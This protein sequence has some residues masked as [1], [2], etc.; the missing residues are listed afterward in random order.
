MA[1]AI[2]RLMCFC[3]ALLLFSS[4]LK[5]D[6]SNISDEFDWE[7]SLSISLSELNIGTDD[8]Y[9]GSFSNNFVLFPFTIDADF[10]AIFSDIENVNE[11]MLRFYVDNHFPASLQCYTFY[12][13]Q[14]DEFRSYFLAENPIN[15]EAA[16]IDSV[17]N[18]K[19]STS[20]IYD[21]YLIQDGVGHQRL[22]EVKSIILYVILSDIDSS[23]A[24]FDQLDNY[25]IT[26]SLG[27]RAAL[28]IPVNQ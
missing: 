7:P 21:E 11:L 17:G 2:N 10:S 28:D 25:H 4:C 18:V 6:L 26:V 12:V 1:F 24:V 15:V 27:I 14:D 19:Q 13:D 20:L 3:C 8:T 23:E 22:S 9:S 16:E 5:E